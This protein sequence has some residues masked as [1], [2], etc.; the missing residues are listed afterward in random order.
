MLNNVDNLKIFVYLALAGTGLIAYSLKQIKKKTRIK[1]LAKQIITSASAGSVEIE[2]VAWPFRAIDTDMEGKKI[3]FRHIEIQEY[4]RR[5]KRGNW[6]T[7]WTKHSTE[8]FLIF[9]YSGYMFVQ[10]NILGSS[11]PHMTEGISSRE[12]SARNLKSLALESFNEFYDGSIADFR[13][14]SSSGFFS[15]FFSFGKRHRI[16]ERSIT[17]GSPILI[18]GHFS[19]EDTPRFIHLK[20]EF[21]LFRQRAARLLGQKSY[22]ITMF[23]KNRDGEVDI[24]EL[25]LGFVAALKNSVKKDFSI[26]DIKSVGE[27]HER[28]CGTIKD[29]GTQDLM[30]VEGLEE[31]I[32][33][34]SPISRNWLCLYLGAAIVALAIFFIMNLY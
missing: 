7:L 25:T 1:N 9:D 6:E 2:A 17:I 14:S 26:T 21:T 12:Y 20:E 23:D 18:H 27:S 4:V 32:L 29:S 24:D 28:L 13:V 5:G 8:P 31:Q 30:L 15:T 3:V 10:P 34:A 22:R 33:N 19:P 16:F 11:D